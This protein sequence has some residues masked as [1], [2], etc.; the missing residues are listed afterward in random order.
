ME[1]GITPAA[2]IGALSCWTCN[3]YGWM[4]GIKCNDG[5][6]C[7]VAMVTWRVLSRNHGSCHVDIAEDSDGMD[8]MDEKAYILD[9][10]RFAAMD[11]I[12]TP[13]SM[14]AAAILPPRMKH[15]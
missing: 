8:G 11:N 4:R 15:T 5:K 10:R 2:V 1:K 12:G 9:E 14:H 3:G 7:N 6:S 13:D